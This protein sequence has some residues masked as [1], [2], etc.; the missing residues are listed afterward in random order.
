M[1]FPSLQAAC[2][3]ASR[4]SSNLPFPSVG[5]VYGTLCGI[6]PT[7]R[8]LRMMGNLIMTALSTR[9]TLI[10]LQ[11]LTC[12]RR[13]HL[14]AIALCLT[15]I[16]LSMTWSFQNRRSRRTRRTLRTLRTPLSIR[17]L[18][19]FSVLRAGRSHQTIRILLTLGLLLT[20]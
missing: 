6:T 13:L 9:I 17:I 5:S 11:L 20:F 3:A 12:P 8:R 2:R 18:R 14:P 15:Q 1:D 4:A 10:Q 7:T 16:W 19:V